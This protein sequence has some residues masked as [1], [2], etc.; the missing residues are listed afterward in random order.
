MCE[1]VY[2]WLMFYFSK[3]LQLIQGGKGEAIRIRAILRS[4]IPIQD[5][6]GVISIAFQIPSVSKGQIRLKCHIT[7]SSHCTNTWIV[8][9]G[10]QLKS[11]SLRWHYSLGNRG[12]VC[13]F[14]QPHCPC[15]STV[16]KFFFLLMVK[17]LS[18]RSWH[19][20][21]H[22]VWCCFQECG[23]EFTAR[24]NIVSIYVNNPWHNIQHAL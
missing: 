7:H 9:Y 11:D 10:C 8:C 1:V 4:L 18:W 5:L 19:V 21:L 16:L 20:Q 13:D 22:A 2:H 15:D 23:P 12:P 24:P 17:W 3:L 14:V 6:E